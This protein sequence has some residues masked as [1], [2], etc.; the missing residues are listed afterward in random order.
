MLDGHDLGALRDA[1]LRA[2]AAIEK[3]ETGEGDDEGIFLGLMI[4]LDAGYEAEIV[5]NADFKDWLLRADYAS[6]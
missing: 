2:V 1:L 4:A 5:T 3:H 6:D